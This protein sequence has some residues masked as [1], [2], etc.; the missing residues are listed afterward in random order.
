MSRQKL[1]DQIAADNGITKTAAEAV[2]RQ[3]TAGVTNVLKSGD[4]VQLVGWGTFE[5]K[6]TEARQG[7]NPRTGG[8]LTI[9]AK[10][11][12]TFKPG[13]TLKAELN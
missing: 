7:R 13:E 2:I 4:K 9:E 11:K 5:S 1:V 10:N 3:F 12:V 6:R 8:T